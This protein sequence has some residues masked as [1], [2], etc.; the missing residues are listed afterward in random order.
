MLCLMPPVKFIG[1][2][3]LYYFFHEFESSNDKVQQYNCQE[4]YGLQGQICLTNLQLNVGI[5]Y[6]VRCAT[7]FEPKKF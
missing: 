2:S 1:C 4:I 6:N 5:R 7:K 3:G